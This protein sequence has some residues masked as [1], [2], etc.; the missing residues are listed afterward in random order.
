[1]CPNVR[2]SGLIPVLFEIANLRD[3]QFCSVGFHQEQ[4]GI[5]SSLSAWAKLTGLFRFFQR[6]YPIYRNG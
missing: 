6:Y 4:T 1:M 5:Y 3:G 2:F